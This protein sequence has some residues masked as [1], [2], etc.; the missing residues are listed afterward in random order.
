MMKLMLALEKLPR[1]A[2]IVLAT[3]FMVA[4]TLIYFLTGSQIAISIFFLAPISIVTWGS[5]LKAGVVFSFL[6]IVGWALADYFNGLHDERLAW[7]L[8]N[9]ILRLLLFVA[10]ASVLAALK[11]LVE[12]HKL[13]ARVDELTGIANRRAFYEAARSEIARANRNP[14]P[15]TVVFTDI[16]NFKKVNDKFGH[17]VGDRL[18][19]MTASIMRQNV[20]EID[21]VARLGGDEFVILL[22]GTDSNGASTVMERLRNDLAEMAR[23]NNWPI[24]FSAGAVTFT[25]PPE[26]VDEMITKADSLMYTV[27]QSGKDHI[28]QESN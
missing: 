18:L 24:S 25:R 17:S 15:F 1:G 27:K 5:G 7:F 20:R 8:V 22:T 12:E 14:G 6:S 16:D 9:E 13:A 4:I 11:R 3:V 21:Q 2:N 10:G 23:Q 26:S 19:S 28:R